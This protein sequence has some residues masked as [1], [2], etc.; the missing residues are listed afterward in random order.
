MTGFKNFDIINNLNEDKDYILNNI[1]E[2]EIISNKTYI[3][4]LPKKINNNKIIVEI[5][6]K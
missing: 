6:K 4:I 2:K 3:Y 1:I 5:P